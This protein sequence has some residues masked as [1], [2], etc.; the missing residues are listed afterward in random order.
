M[1]SIT[2]GDMS[3]AAL[4]AG[5]ARQEQITL[6]GVRGGCTT[7]TTV[8]VTANSDGLVGESDAGHDTNNTL[9]RSF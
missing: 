9:S 3:S 8:T 4:A 1:F 5:A 7:G 6:G 2:S